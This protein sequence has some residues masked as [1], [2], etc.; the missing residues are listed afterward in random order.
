[1]GGETVLEGALAPE[2]MTRELLSLFSKSKLS[3]L[4]LSFIAPHIR[5]MDCCPASNTIGGSG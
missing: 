3:S 5:L 1:M 4:R 2:Q